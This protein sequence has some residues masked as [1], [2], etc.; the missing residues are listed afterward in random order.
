V[1][2]SLRRHA[3]AFLV[4]EMARTK[5]WPV[6]ERNCIIMVWFDAEDREPMF[7]PREFEEVTELGWEV[8]AIGTHYFH[9]HISVSFT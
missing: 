5:S 2:D 4:P 9:A 6:L 3:L 7:L 1:A 8:Q